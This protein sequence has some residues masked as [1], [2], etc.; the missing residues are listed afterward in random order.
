MLIE[1]SS[2]CS[3]IANISSDQMVTR[4]IGDRSIDI[5]NVTVKYQLVHIDEH[6]LRPDTEQ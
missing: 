1:E 2:E 4:R 3:L 5:A 6:R